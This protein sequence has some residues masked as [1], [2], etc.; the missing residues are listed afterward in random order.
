MSLQVKIIK[1]IPKETI[2]KFE[3]RVVY[4]TAV[5]TREYT[6]GIGAYPHLTGKLERTESAS[7]ITSS[8]KSTYNLLAGVN[9][10]KKVYNYTKARWTNPT[11]IPQWYYNV[12][13][14]YQASILKSATTKANKEIK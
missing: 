4:N 14:K 3:D 9:Y 7:P 12:Y 11:T 8:G 10:A 6:K 13:R 2:E 1:D 5:E